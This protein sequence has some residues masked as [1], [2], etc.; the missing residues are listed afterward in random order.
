MM[1]SISGSFASRA[2]ADT[3]KKDVY[4]WDAEVIH[5]SAM[6]QN[7]LNQTTTLD[8]TAKKLQGKIVMVF[9]D[10]LNYM[11]K[12][13]EHYPEDQY[14]KE[15]ILRRSWIWE[16]NIKWIDRYVNVSGWIERNR[17]SFNKIRKANV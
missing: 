3:K 4:V 5:S 14:A 15:Y 17:K 1:L 6:P 10:Q 8:G 12:R 2:L 9:S 11:L 13:A 16:K 7:L